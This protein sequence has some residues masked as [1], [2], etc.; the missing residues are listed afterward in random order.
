MRVQ[1][2]LHSDTSDHMAI[3][4]ETPLINGLYLACGFSGHGFMHSPSVGRLI[5]DLILGRPA[6][7]FDAELLGLDRFKRYIEPKESV[8][9]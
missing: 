6:P 7:L 5:A 3:L 1:A 4:G 9:I 2:G 8:F